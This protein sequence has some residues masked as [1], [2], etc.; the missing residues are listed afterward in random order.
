MSRFRRRPDKTD[1][2]SALV[3][4][5]GLLLIIDPRGRPGSVELG[6]ALLAAGG[7]PIGRTLHARR[8]SR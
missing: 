5:A 1:W 7:I 6:L 8:R 4:V 3:A 2:L